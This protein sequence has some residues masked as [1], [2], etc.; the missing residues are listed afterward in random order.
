MSDSR[1]VL[2]NYI[3]FTL[4][5]NMKNIINFIFYTRTLRHTRATSFGKILIQHQ[6]KLTHN[7]VVVT[8]IDK[9]WQDHDVHAMLFTFVSMSWC[10]SFGQQSHNKHSSIE[11]CWLFARRHTTCHWYALCRMLYVLYC[12]VYVCSVAYDLFRW[13]LQDDIIFVLLICRMV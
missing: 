6:P 5:H 2:Q 11:A 12:L 1:V 3:L 13:Q 4:L 8:H 9:C 10:L 7:L